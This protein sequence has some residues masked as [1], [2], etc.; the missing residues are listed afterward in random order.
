MQLGLHNLKLLAHLLRRHF[1]VLVGCNQIR[2][3]F[4]LR[5]ALAN[6]AHQLRRNCRVCKDLRVDLDGF[7]QHRKRLI[8]SSL[9]IG[10]SHHAN[11]ILAQGQVVALALLACL[12]VNAISREDLVNRYRLML[13]IR[14]HNLHNLR[15][16]HDL[17]EDHA[18]LLVH[19]GFDTVQVVGIAEVRHVRLAAELLDG[20]ARLIALVLAQAGRIHAGD[21]LKLLSKEPAQRQQPLN[22]RFPLV[23]LRRR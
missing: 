23:F 15:P 22:R 6:H 12:R 19:D 13:G 3:A 14:P 11:R 9:E 1:L 17:G 2:N 16:G 20:L 18:H 10:S 4:H 8:L 5:V 21:G 7:E